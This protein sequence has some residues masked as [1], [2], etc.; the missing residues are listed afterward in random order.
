[1]YNRAD[2]IKPYNRPMYMDTL[3]KQET[4]VH[5]QLTWVACSGMSASVLDVDRMIGFFNAYGFEQLLCICTKRSEGCIS[6]KRA[7][8]SSPLSSYL[9]ASLLGLDRHQLF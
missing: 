7:L 8:L 3:T 2:T 4:I 1:M 9:M 5:R 6:E